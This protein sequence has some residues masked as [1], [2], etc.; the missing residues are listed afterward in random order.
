MNETR[1]S[2]ES[3]SSYSGSC[4]G[5]LKET[6]NETYSAI[7]ES[8]TIF[9]YYSLAS[10]FLVL[11][12]SQGS[13]IETWPVAPPFSGLLKT[14][15]SHGNK[16]VLDSNTL[17]DSGPD[18]VTNESSIFSKL[19]FRLSKLSLSRTLKIFTHQS[20]QGLKREPRSS[21]C[22]VQQKKSTRQLITVHLIPHSKPKS[23]YPT[24]ILSCTSILSLP[25]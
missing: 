1:F 19:A 25:V 23:H 12:L 10:R 13:H 24:L 14:N 3:Q 21:V 18:L 17:S 20:N 8:I 15:Q 5:D 2:C 6:D 22:D 16:E 9:A 11:N 4:P 7:L